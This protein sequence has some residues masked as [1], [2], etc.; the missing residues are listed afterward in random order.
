MAK[1]DGLRNPPS[2]GNI[3]SS[4]KYD[5]AMF[6]TFKPN[7]KARKKNKMAKNSRKKNR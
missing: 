6:Q 7:K 4:P 1:P 3:V 2:N 5:G